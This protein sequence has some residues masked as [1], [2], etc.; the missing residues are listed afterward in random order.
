MTRAFVA[1]GAVL[2][3]AACGGGAS[4][5]VGPPSAQNVAQDSGDFS[6]LQKCPETGSYDSYLNQEK[7]QAPDQY[8]TDAKDW[9]DLKAAGAD[10]AWVAAY[11]ENT[12]DC[13]QFGTGTPTGKFAGIFAFRFKQAANASSSYK[14][15]AAQFHLS[16]TDVAN[17]QA[18][19]GAVKQ[20]AAT[21]L[22]DNSIAVSFNLAGTTFYVALWQNKEFEVA[23]L[24]YNLPANQGPATATRINGRIH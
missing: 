14:T 7:T 17:I 1:A 18:A 3:V 23:I 2:L 20:G 11:A 16:A 19:G 6:G 4:S 8:A 9:T 22:G 15:Q 12:T 21:G 24:L 5:A 13:A 10:D